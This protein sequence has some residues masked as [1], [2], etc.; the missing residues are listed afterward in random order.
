MEHESKSLF[1]PV[2]MI[3]RRNGKVHRQRYWQRNESVSDQ[4]EQQRSSN[5]K[6]KTPK[7]NLDHIIAEQSLHRMRTSAFRKLRRM[8]AHLHH[9]HRKIDTF[10]NDDDSDEKGDDK[11]NPLTSWV[12]NAH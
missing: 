11:N 12:K 3:V 6:K 4:T 9:T 8:F 1:V 7:E 2:T 10:L 5:D